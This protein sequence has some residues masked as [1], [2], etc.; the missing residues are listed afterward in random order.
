MQSLLE[1]WRTGE[2]HQ[3]VIDGHGEYIG[4]RFPS[5]PNGQNFRLETFPVADFAWRVNILEE[6]HLQF[7]HPSSFAAF[8]PP[9][10]CVERKVTRRKTLPPCVAF[11]GKELPDLIEGFQIGNWIRS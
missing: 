4:D 5:K 7:L 10:R 1:L 2:E 3:G 9:P 8:A 6:V 11:R